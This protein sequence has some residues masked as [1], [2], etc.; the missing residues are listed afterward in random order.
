MSKT[1]YGN[2]LG[3]ETLRAGKVLTISVD[4]GGGAIVEQF[5]D[6]RK[7]AGSDITASTAFGPFVDDTVLKVSA[8][9]GATVTI[10]DPV[11]Q[12]A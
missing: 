5:N 6:G 9:A 10:G 12:V 11:D 8:K 7:I 1:L 4:A 3:S 2:Q